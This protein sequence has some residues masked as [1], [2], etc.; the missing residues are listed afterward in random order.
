MYVLLN[1]PPNL[2]WNN[3]TQSQFHHMFRAIKRRL[4]KL[5]EKCKG[6][7]F[8]IKKGNDQLISEIETVAMLNDVYGLTS[9]CLAGLNTK[10]MLPG[11]AAVTSADFSEILEDRVDY[12]Y[13]WNSVSRRL[14]DPYTQANPKLQDIARSLE[15]SVTKHEEPQG[16]TIDHVK[17]LQDLRELKTK[18]NPTLASLEMSG[19][20]TL[21][22]IS[23]TGM[24]SS[25]EEY[26]QQW[27]TN[28]RILE[29]II[30]PLIKAI[31]T[32]GKATCGLQ[33]KEMKDFLPYKILPEL[34]NKEPTPKIG[35]TQFTAKSSDVSQV[36]G[37]N[38]RAREYDKEMKEVRVNYQKNDSTGFGALNDI[39]IMVAQTA[40]AS[41]IID[42]I[43][44]AYAEEGILE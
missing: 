2:A 9:V 30:L 44:N 29:T 36:L 28:A 22:G 32:I 16:S 20:S 7:P 12:S 27:S 5:Q 24:E 38:Q 35:V 26:Q 8:K 18:P 6:K 1:I 19:K 31:A 15:D 41:K 14:P 21:K 13:S 25:D 4:Q 39:M 37:P 3:W 42:I 34:L 33:I 40:K 23:Y 10:L 11:V 43:M 17:A